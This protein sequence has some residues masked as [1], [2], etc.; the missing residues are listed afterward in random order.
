VVRHSGHHRAHGPRLP[1]GRRE[2]LGW[3]RPRAQPVPHRPLPGTRLLRVAGRRGARPPAAA[4]REDRRGPEVRQPRAGARGRARAAGAGDAAARRERP[5]R[6]RRLP[7]KGSGQRHQPLAEQLF[8]KVRAP[9]LRA[10]FRRT[11]GRWRFDAVQAIGIADIPS[12]DRA[13]LLETVK[14]SWPTRRRRRGSNAAAAI[15][16]GSRSCGIRRNRTSLPTRK[17]CKSWCRWRPWWDWRPS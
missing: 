10:V 12:Q 2:R 17:R 14:A 5:V 16:R 11:D 4:R 7:G 6:A 15:A 13:F 9:L 8:A 1:V 3:Q